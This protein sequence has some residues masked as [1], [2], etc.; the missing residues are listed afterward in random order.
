MSRRLAALLAWTTL[1]LVVVALVPLIWLQAANASGTAVDIAIGALTQLALVTVGALVA[2]LRPRNL[3]GW[4]FCGC[5]LVSTLGNV[6]DEYGV[7]A[8][9]TTHR[10][11]P[12]AVLAGVF[13]AW[14][15]GLGWFPLVTLLPL[16]FPDG[17]LPSRRWWPVAWL[18]GALLAV[19]SVAQVFGQGAN[20]DNRLT[21]VANPI[22]WLGPDI[23]NVL[24]NIFVLLLGPVVGLCIAAVIVRLR[25]SSGIERQRLKWF[26]Y[27]A[28]LC[29]AFVFVIIIADDF[30]NGVGVPG[31]LFDLAV[32]GMPVAAGIAILRHR[33]YDIDVIINRTLVYGS[34][35][36]L[37][38][39]VYFGSVIGMQHVAAAMAGAQAADNPL[40]IVLSTLLIAALFTP[41]RRRLQR[42]ID[43]RFYRARYDTARTLERFAATLRQQIELS[44]LN[45]HLVG[46]VEE[47][48]H[49]AHVSLWLRPPMQDEVRR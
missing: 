12:G 43:R 47:T 26:A 4:M 42:T 23:T 36:L 37:L 31:S 32:A 49:P 13:G 11:L 46:V 6:G 45:A 17:R 39:A 1:A 28:V 29:L 21:A 24:Q 7:Y 22:G 40:I 35:T 3:I 14:G 41:L 16:L 5:A 8:L 19:F 33:L 38:A 48:M 9:I 18:A 15:R 34:L 27:A 10:P 25:R 44:A 20:G 2:A 30:T